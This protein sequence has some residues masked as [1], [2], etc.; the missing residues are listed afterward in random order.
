MGGRGGERDPRPASRVPRVRVGEAGRPGPPKCGEGGKG[1]ARQRSARRLGRGG[2]VERVAGL[3]GTVSRRHRGSS[4]TGHGR[5]RTRASDGRDLVGC[6]AGGRRDERARERTCHSLL[7]SPGSGLRERTEPCPPRE[8][9]RRSTAPLAG[10]AQGRAFGRAASG[11]ARCLPTCRPR[12][13]TPHTVIL[14]PP[15]SFVWHLRD[16]PVRSKGHG[17][18]SGK[19]LG[20]KR[21]ALLC[22]K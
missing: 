13:D 6:P 21:Q 17:T 18:I 7:A 16:N 8:G 15:W 11:P 1:G 5:R 22:H 2:P 19:L 20:Y 9:S 14:R 3:A 4:R 12:A 10:T